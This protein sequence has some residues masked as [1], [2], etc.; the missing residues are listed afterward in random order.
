[1]LAL[2]LLILAAILL[3]GLTF[4]RRRSPASLRLIE[5]MSVESL[6]GLAV[7]NGRVCISHWAQNLI[8][9]R[10]WFGIC[11]ISHAAR[12]ANALRSVIVRLY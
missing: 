11:Q 4:L 9:A 1:M 7:E 6:I 5:R 12:L 10:R 3:L 8:S 2:G